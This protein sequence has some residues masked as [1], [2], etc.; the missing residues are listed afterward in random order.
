MDESFEAV[1][2]DALR[3]LEDDDPPAAAPLPLPQRSNARGRGGGMTFDPLRGGRG[4]GMA[5]DPLRGA[6]LRG[7]GRGR[8]R[9][10]TASQ[11]QPPANLDGPTNREDVDALC[12]NLTGLLTELGTCEGAERGEADGG[13]GRF[14]DFQATLDALDAATRE[15]MG[16][17]SSGSGMPGVPQMPPMPPD[18]SN[19]E[20]A[21]VEVVMRKLLSK[22]MLHEPLK[23][24]SQQY[25]V[26]F[27]SMEG[28]LTAEELDQYR[29]QHDMIKQICEV[30]DNRP[31]DYETLINL[32]QGVQACGQPPKEIIE[33]VAPELGG[34]QGGAAADFGLGTQ[35]CLQQ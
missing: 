18:G 14:A 28:K 26:W 21:L 32:F 12:K 34:L 15:G 5:F 13:A 29:R 9:G 1:L 6:G 27:D 25:P 8:G 33:S 7:R 30:Y 3:D 16:A 11:Q 35:D 2:Q 10:G 17:S 24:I 23:E 22:D 20:H 19:P 4:G 31:D